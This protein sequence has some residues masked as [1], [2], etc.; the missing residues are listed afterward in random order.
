MKKRI[1]QLIY[2]QESDRLSFDGEDLHCGECLEVMVC[3]GLNGDQAEWIATRL[4]YNDH[5]YLVGL[6]GY[7]VSGL[8]ARR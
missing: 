5:W 2:D 1:A 4:E 8:F 6:L 3:N 7:Q